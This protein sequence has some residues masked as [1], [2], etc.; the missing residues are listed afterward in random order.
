MNSL[1][2]IALYFVMFGVSLYGLS[3]VNFSA[4]MHPAKTKQAQVLIIL[5]AMGLA[6]L[7]TQFLLGLRF[8]MSS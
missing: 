6:Y 5:L 1:V 3:A 8:F 4:L 2:S 7:A